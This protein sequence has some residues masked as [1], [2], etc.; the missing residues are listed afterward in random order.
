MEV[1]E[2]DEIDKI[3]REQ[4]MASALD[5]LTKVRS[6]VQSKSTLGSGSIVEEEESISIY[7][8][9]SNSMSDN[10]NKKQKG[11][12]MMNNE[13]NK[14]IDSNSYD[15]NDLNRKSGSTMKSLIHELSAKNVE[16]QS[17]LMQLNHYKLQVQALSSR[18]KEGRNK[19]LLLQQ[20]LA[21]VERQ[22]IQL[23][24]AN[25][26]IATFENMSHSYGGMPHSQLEMNIDMNMRTLSSHGN[27]NNN[28]QQ[29]TI[30]SKLLKEAEI[31]IHD[32]ENQLIHSQDSLRSSIAEKEVLNMKYTS[33][34]SAIKNELNS[35]V[36]ELATKT[37]LHDVQKRKLQSN[38]RRL[39]NTNVRLQEELESTQSELVTMEEQYKLL[40]I[41]RLRAETNAKEANE[42]RNRLNILCNEQQERI[43]R[44]DSDLADATSLVSRLQETTDRLKGSDIV[45]IER[46]MTTELDTIRAESRE[47]EKVL[48]SQLDQALSRLGEE[49]GL[50]Q[51][52]LDELNTTREELYIH[53]ER[54]GM[55]TSVNSGS[56]SGAV[57]N[58]T[59]VDAID[60]R[61]SLRESDGSSSSINTRRR[62]L[63]LLDNNNYDNS[64]PSKFNSSGTGIDVGDATRLPRPNPLNWSLELTTSSFNNNNNNNNIDNSS[65]YSSMDL[66]RSHDN[67]NNN[68]NLISRMRYSNDS[69][70]ADDTDE[71]EDVG[72]G[73]G[74]GIGE[75]THRMIAK[76]DSVLKA[77]FEGRNGLTGAIDGDAPHA[78][79]DE[80]DDNEGGVRFSLLMGG[81]D[82]ESDVF[83]DD[84]DDDNDNNNGNN[85][86][87]SIDDFIKEDRERDSKDS[88]DVPSI[89]LHHQHHQQAQHQRLISESVDA[90][91]LNVDNSN[92]RVNTN[93]ELISAS[94]DTSANMQYRI[95]RKTSTHS[96]S[97]T[98]AT[99]KS[100]N[101]S[102]RSNKQANNKNDPNN[103]TKSKITINVANTSN[104]G[105]STTNNSDNSNTFSSK[106]PSAGGTRQLQEQI[107]IYKHREVLLK[108]AIGKWRVQANEAYDKCRKNDNLTKDLL[109]ITKICHARML[110]NNNTSNNNSNKDHSSNNDIESLTDPNK[111]LKILVKCI[112]SVNEK[113]QSLV[114]E[115]DRL[116][117]EVSIFEERLKSYQDELIIAQGNTASAQQLGESLAASKFEKEIVDLKQRLSELQQPSQPSLQPGG[118]TPSI[119]TPSTA[120]TRQTNDSNNNNNNNSSSSSSSSSSNGS[121]S[122]VGKEK[123]LV[124][125][126]SLC[127]AANMLLH[128]AADSDDEEAHESHELASFEEAEFV[129]LSDR[130]VSLSDRVVRALQASQHDNEYLKQENKILN[131]NNSNN[132]SNN[133]NNNNNTTP[134]S[135]TDAVDTTD[136]LNAQAE[137]QKQVFAAVAAAVGNWTSQFDVINEKLNHVSTRSMNVSSRVNELV[138]SRTN[139]TNSNTNNG[140][141][142]SSSN[143]S[144]G[145]GESITARMQSSSSSPS[146]RL[147]LHSFDEIMLS[148]RS[149]RDTLHNLKQSVHS[150][151]RQASLHSS[152]GLKQLAA[153]ALRRLS[154]IEA[155][156]EEELDVAMSRIQ[157]LE[158]EQYTLR[159]DIKK[160]SEQFLLHKEEAQ[161]QLQEQLKQSRSLSDSQV[162][163][164]KELDKMNN[165]ELEILKEKHRQELDRVAQS[166]KEHLEEFQKEYRNQQRSKYKIRLEKLRSEFN[167]ERGVILD[168]VKHE[169]E[170]IME[171]ARRLFKRKKDKDNMKSNNQL[172]S[173]KRNTGSTATTDNDNSNR[174][175]NRSDRGGNNN[176]KSGHYGKEKEKQ[177]DEIE[178]LEDML[179]LPSSLSAPAASQPPLLPPPP[180]Q[181]PQQQEQQ[182]QQRLPQQ[183]QAPPID[184]D[185]SSSANTHHTTSN[186][187]R[188]TYNTNNS[189][190]TN[191]T[192]GSHANNFYPEKV[193]PQDT[194]VLMKSILGR[195]LDD[196][197][198]RGTL[199]QG[200]LSASLSSMSVID[201]VNEV[202][203]I[204]DDD[205]K[206]DI[207]KKNKVGS[208]QATPM[209]QII[210]PGK[211]IV[212]D[213]PSRMSSRS[214]RKTSNA[215]SEG[216][217]SNGITTNNHN[218][219]KVE[220]QSTAQVKARSMQSISKSY[221]SRSSKTSNNVS[222]NK[223]LPAGVRPPTKSRGRIPLMT[224]SSS[225][226]NSTSKEVGK[227]K[228][229]S[230]IRGKDGVDTTAAVHTSV[231]NSNI[232]SSNEKDSLLK[233]VDGDYEVENNNS[234]DGAKA[235]ETSIDLMEKDILDMQIS[236]LRTPERA[237]HGT[238]KMIKRLNSE[239]NSTPRTSS[240]RTSSSPLDTTPKPQHSTPLPLMKP[241]KSTPKRGN[242]Q[243]TG[244]YGNS[245]GRLLSPTPGNSNA[246][247][248]TKTTNTTSIPVTRRYR[249]GKSSNNATDTT[250]SATTST[251][252]D[253]K[254]SMNRKRS[255]YA[256][257][258]SMSWFS[259][260]EKE[261]EMEKH[262]KK[263]S[264][265]AVSASVSGSS[266]GSSF[267]R[268]SKE[269][270]SWLGL[271]RSRSQQVKKDAA[272]SKGWR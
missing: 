19:L 122:P 85:N 24:A 60:L 195:S 102:N 41:Q 257:S 20:E 200:D 95:L 123:T 125:W 242:P 7:S 67:N 215:R 77:S 9:K 207:Q 162:Q 171:E 142:N 225:N 165:M 160:R 58:T 1:S 136:S 73:V 87:N 159:N 34:I 144:N 247:K 161:L 82:K 267:L 230:T 90:G 150:E 108:A 269:S 86:R 178:S 156:R 222:N 217:S 172:Q 100:S 187:S 198:F 83:D 234:Y 72:I 38:N 70:R 111:A 174:Y 151:L 63:S 29:I 168:M 104:V 88:D 209:S 140:D 76:V 233:I 211:P 262:N 45:D 69:N 30:Q 167:E 132:D 120:N 21:S 268:G 33:E 126:Q 210:Q 18:E 84:D 56:N 52:L 192:H 43:I 15:M 148:I 50:R 240:A 265:A 243:R 170:E 155:A 244:A 173:S 239:S 55:N 53:R 139:N 51:G 206:S 23:E 203:Q 65:N 260:K 208:S 175:Y 103:S 101:N 81:G 4:E 28:H 96:N 258:W 97:N 249:T 12:D 40:D 128:A 17:L 115:R 218:N 271:S 189:N 91:H 26:D 14:D 259:S 212:S 229:S 157:D 48:R 141:S 184:T 135:D 119:S 202:N 61:N 149:S 252:N 154:E 232:A 8:N 107:T 13:N 263:K 194:K 105:S 256:T 49:S 46:E 179:G 164:S 250:A 177:E 16:N 204:N 196:G 231:S 248:N 270:S 124:I 47:R 183:L 237:I 224:S 27:N 145:N 10:N 116:E 226:S 112:K 66:R 201:E 223:T 220:L 163:Q 57:I 94:L 146:N 185:D 118:T 169:C 176:E 236:N 79:N 11:N 121:S 3:E 228:L 117:A 191:D 261:R 131:R 25:V 214:S 37:V 213:S 130:L 264:R 78:T 166:W 93:D 143:A 2:I 221:A 254:T 235:T 75:D 245:V 199:H 36:D 137:A 99:T 74:V 181:Q 31:Q 197:E 138:Q 71:G 134:S 35:K 246:T 190:N 80:N 238:N 205:H 255:P 114:V 152:I 64:R 62:S 153:E 5:K 44:L 32:L 92:S 42:G 227:S 193:A 186:T 241:L 22:K 272:R 127:R 266:S 251:N 219:N 253:I 113:S 68:N 158:S 39:E 129:H 54:S 89:L 182:Q 98:I 216:N 147:S 106:T 59:G 188:V 180:R 109:K 110:N 6:S 133:N